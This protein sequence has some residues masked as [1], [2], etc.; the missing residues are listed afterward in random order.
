MVEDFDDYDGRTA[1]VFTAD[2]GMGLKGAH[3]DGDPA[4]TRTP[5]VVWGAGVQG[6]TVGSKSGNFEIDLPTQSRTQVRA[7]LQ[8][9][10][11]QELA[12]VEEW[13]ALGNLMRKDVMQADVAPLI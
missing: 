12:A 9:Q 7:Q 11:E 2:H 6:P 4:N 8:A 10:E 1:Y 3:G 5:L 13:G